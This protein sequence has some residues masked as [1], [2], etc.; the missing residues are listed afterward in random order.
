MLPHTPIVRLQCCAPSLQA[1]DCLMEQC[2]IPALQVQAVSTRQQLLVPCAHCAHIQQDPN[3]VAD[4]VKELR[5]YFVHQ[6]IGGAC[7]GV[8]HH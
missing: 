3:V 5:R 2:C 1:R 4:F 6:V 7:Q 8:Q